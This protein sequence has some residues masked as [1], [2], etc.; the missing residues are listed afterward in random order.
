MRVSCNLCNEVYQA[1]T[2]HKCKPRPTATSQAKPAASLAPVTNVTNTAVTNVTNERSSPPLVTDNSSRRRIVSDKARVIRWRAKNPEHYRMYMA[3][4]M[5]K[6][7]AAKATDDK[8][9]GLP[10]SKEI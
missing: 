6:W 1:G 7:R 3:D 2:G 4:Y 10:A 9:F 5:R 8:H